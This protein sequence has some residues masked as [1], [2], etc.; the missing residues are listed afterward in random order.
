MF[1]IAID[2]APEVRA[3]APLQRRWQRNLKKR[4]VDTGA[5]YRAVGRLM[6]LTR[7]LSPTTGKG[8][9]LFLKIFRWS[10]ALKRVSSR[11]LSTEKT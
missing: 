9:R 4:Y 11:S 6:P 7:A 1:N 10:C 5:L 2:G 3:K 8:F